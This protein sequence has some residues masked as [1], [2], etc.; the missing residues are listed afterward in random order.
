M[1]S[2][3]YISVVVTSARTAKIL[4]EIDKVDDLARTELR[5]LLERKQKS[6]EM[7][8]AKLAQMTKPLLNLINSVLATGFFSSFSAGSSP[9]KNWWSPPSRKIITV[10]I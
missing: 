10:A 8:R 5:L 7:R 6:K 2:G 4:R 9:N 3:I 1:P